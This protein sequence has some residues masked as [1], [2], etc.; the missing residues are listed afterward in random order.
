MKSWLQKHLGAVLVAAAIATTG[1]GILVVTQDPPVDPGLANLWID[2]NGGTCVRQSSATAYADASAC[3]S[4]D[5]AYTAASCGDTVRIKQ[6][7][8]FY[9]DQDIVDTQKNCSQYITFTPASGE[10]VQVGGSG[11]TGGINI[12][13]ADWIKF[14][15]VRTGSNS[16]FKL[17]DSGTD[18]SAGVVMGF[19]GCQFGA[20]ER[21]DHIWYEGMSFETFLIRGADQISFID[22][23]IAAGKTEDFDET[24]FISNGFD[25]SFQDNYATDILFEKNDIHNFTSDE[26]AGVN[27]CHIECLTGEFENLIFRQNRMYDCGNT[28]ALIFSQDA[29]FST[30]GTGNIVEN[31]LI[32][33]NEN[34]PLQF[35][36][37][38]SGS[39]ITVRSNTVRR[40]GGGQGTTGTALGGVLAGTIHFIGNVVEGG[41]GMSCADIDGTWSYNVLDDNS[42]GC[43]TGG[44]S[45]TVADTTFT[46]GIPDFHLSTSQ[47]AE[48][49]IPTGSCP[50]TVD[51]DGQSRP[52]GSACDSG[53]D[54]RG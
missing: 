12:C 52:I 33:D 14:K 47:V 11:S 48:D 49:K 27:G 43:T 20:S 39:V 19:G 1:G 18:S 7:P 46:G 44:T 45:N 15:G 5:A 6:H 16:N 40:T 30:K 42:S 37:T 9:A 17:V 3:S 51:L 31:N 54:E 10:T 35:G 34:I 26:C 23:D 13:D 53:A 32:H 50:T 21:V 22:N 41:N 36:D 38:E 4:F 28:A 29:G 24:N 8:T 2:S 25:G